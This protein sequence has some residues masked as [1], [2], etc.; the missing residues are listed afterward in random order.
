MEQKPIRNELPPSRQSVTLEGTFRG[1]YRVFAVFLICCA[2]LVAA[3]AFS[4]VWMNKGG[5][6]WF[7]GMGGET[8]TAQKNGSDDDGERE[9]VPGEIPPS[10]QIPE[11]ATPVRSMD[12]AYLERG[13]GYLHND[14]AYHPDVEGLLSLELTPP[15]LSDRPLVLILHTHTSESYLPEGTEYITSPLG[16]LTYSRDETQ[17]VLSVGETLCRALNEKGI[18]ALHCTVMHD[19]PTL[20]GSYRRS[21]ETVKRYLEEYPSIEYV[22]DLHRDAV[23]T[24]EGTIVRA[25]GYDTKGEPI[26][27]IMPVVGTDGNGSDYTNWEENLAFALQLREQ[28]NGKGNAICRPVYLRNESFGQELAKYSV[29]LEIGTAANS[30]EE[31]TRAALMLAEAL[32]QM[33]YPLV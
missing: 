26:A 14:T 5:E 4:A 30:I 8:E 24:S 20:N 11:N 21:E 12:L 25:V 13:K 10:S 1:K 27:Q 16:D 2:L 19:D 22:I 15:S 18:T 23:T 29:L 9:T 7:S 33:I 32:A 3:F 28:L 31:A 17:N 6:S